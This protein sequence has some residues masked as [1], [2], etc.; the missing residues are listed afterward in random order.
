MSETSPAAP[1]LDSDAI[2]Q[3]RAYHRRERNAGYICCLLGVLVM[4]AGRYMTGAPIW[5]V[6][7]GLTVVLFGWGL[8]AFALIKRVSLAR[9][10]SARAGG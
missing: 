8:L 2:Q 9:I 7:V 4:I 3:I 5:L 6:N 10:L 1:Q